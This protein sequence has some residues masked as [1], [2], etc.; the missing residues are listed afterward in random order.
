[1]T[2]Q[3]CFIQASLDCVWLYDQQ[4]QANVYANILKK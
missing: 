2:A 1:M 4:T 3:L